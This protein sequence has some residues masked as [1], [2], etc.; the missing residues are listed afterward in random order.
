MP[1]V[2]IGIGAA[3]PDFDPETYFTRD[4]L[5]ILDRYSQLAVIA[6]QQAV[7]DAS[8]VCGERYSH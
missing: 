1:G 4:E 8:L 2:K 7:D 5:T 3:V 6:A